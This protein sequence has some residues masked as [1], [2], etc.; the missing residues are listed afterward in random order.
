[1]AQMPEARGRV[2]K[3][4]H[5]PYVSAMERV[6]RERERMFEMVMRA[7]ASSSPEWAAARIGQTAH[8]SA[9]MTFDEVLFWL[10]EQLCN[11]GS[12]SIAS[13]GG[14]PQVLSAD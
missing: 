3:F 5:A 14:K 12:G 13:F 2:V 4:Y 11:H 9:G 10:Y 1:M 6:E 7:W 8:A